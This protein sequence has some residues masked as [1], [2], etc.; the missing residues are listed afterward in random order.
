MGI[1][2]LAINSLRDDE[3][4]EKFYSDPDAMRTYIDNPQNFRTLSSLIN[5]TMI[6]KGLCN[7]DTNITEVKK[8]LRNL[9]GKVNSFNADNDSVR[10]RIDDWMGDKI[11]SIQK[12]DDA[13]ELCYALGLNLKETNTFLNKAGFCSLSIRNA[14]HAIH[15]YCFLNG[16]SLE[17]F[18]K[19]YR[20]YLEAEYDEISPDNDEDKVAVPDNETD[21]TTELMLKLKNS[22]WESDE[23][24][25]N[26]FL[27]PSKSNFINYSKRALT[28]YYRI[29]SI[30]TVTVAL[31]LAEKSAN[32]TDDMG[33]KDLALQYKLRSTLRNYK[34][35]QATKD[36]EE[37][38]K[39]AL[40]NLKYPEIPHT[41]SA[42]KNGVILRETRETLYTLR[43]AV[44]EMNE[45]KSL[46]EISAFLNTVLTIEGAYKQILPSLKGKDNRIRNTK[47]G[48]DKK[49]AAITQ[50]FPT[51]RNIAEYEKGL[52]TNHL[53]EIPKPDDKH[54]ILR[55]IIILLYFCIFCHESVICNFRPM[56]DYP[57]LKMI[58]EDLSFDTFVEITNKTLNLNSLP[59]LYPPNKFDFLILIN[60]RNIQEF[61]FN[62]PDE[63]LEYFSKVLGLMFGDSPEE[64]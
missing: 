14:K 59:P 16:R 19:L 64:K 39:S 24:F 61:D 58:F 52:K 7:E 60:V 10:S 5:E 22:D 49:Y 55:K 2:D 35:D 62:D 44:F 20:Q 48:L 56:K 23:Q 31:N 38:L 50:D 63:P 17:D 46:E 40:D 15:Y 51:P 6:S 28:D 29:K 47:K 8:I 37:L 33:K 41:D 9:L 57:D 30:F 12:F 26:S 18:N 1:T 34:Y 32:I 11:E 42:D 13:I 53:G 45:L 3:L 4:L 43:N 54:I 36:V 27:I 25:L 21:S